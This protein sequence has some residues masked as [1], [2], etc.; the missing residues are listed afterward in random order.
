MRVYNDEIRPCKSLNDVKST[1]G[2]IL[3]KLPIYWQYKPSR[4]QLKLVGVV[5]KVYK[6]VWVLK[7]VLKPFRNI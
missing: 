2:A 1:K 7:V 6:L 4:A 3:C 5:V